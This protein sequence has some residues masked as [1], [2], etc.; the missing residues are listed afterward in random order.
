VSADA[1]AEVGAAG[2]IDPARAGPSIELPAPTASPLYFALG[3]SLLFAGLV[4]NVIVSVVGLLTAV[5]GAIGWWRQ[6]L[7]VEHEVAI[8]ASDPVPAV[9][10]RAGSVEHLEVGREGHRVRLP[11][12]YHPYGAG[13]RGGLF[14]GFAMAAVA[15]AHGIVGSGSPW[16]PINLVA[17]VLLP[18]LDASSPLLAE[19]HFVGFVTAVLIHLSLSLLV[20]LVYAAVLPMLPGRPLAWGGIVAPFVWSGVAWAAIE[21]VAP[22]LAVHVDWAVFVASQVAF[23]VVAG[24][25]IARRAK[26]ET[27]QSLSLAARAGLET[28]GTVDERGEPGR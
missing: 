27:F 14:G 2:Q 26:I 10:T 3:L 25:T 8:V 23:G 5:V 24:A 12:H 15:I 18:S 7:P 11:L 16:L 6:V 17:G 21:L 20:G 1:R 13:L 4:T 9:T 19:F 28:A 22:A